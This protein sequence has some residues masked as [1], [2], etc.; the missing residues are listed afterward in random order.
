MIKNIRLYEA[1]ERT[2]D[3]DAWTGRTPEES[4]S[5]GEALLTSEVMAIA[6]FVEGDHPRSLAIG[7]GIVRRAK[8]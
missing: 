5:L 8:Q 3:G 6:E 4:I 1:L 7:L 2:R